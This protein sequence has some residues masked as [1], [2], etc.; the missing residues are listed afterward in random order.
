IHRRPPLAVFPLSASQKRVCWAT[1]QEIRRPPPPS[2]H[3]PAGGT[4]TGRDVAIDKRWPRSRHQLTRVG[5]REN[6]VAPTLAHGKIG[7]KGAITGRGLAHGK[8]GGKGATT[9]RTGNQAWIHIRQ[10]KRTPPV[11][12]QP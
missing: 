2:T 4:A 12:P 6:E 7:G 5:S 11:P 3:Q 1:S 9:N 10:K 8:V